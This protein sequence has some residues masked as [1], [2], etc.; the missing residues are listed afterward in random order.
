M[1]VTNTTRMGMLFCKNSLP[2]IF[3][4]HNEQT[5]F[6]ED[7]GHLCQVTYQDHKCNY[8]IQQTSI[9]EIQI[10]EYFSVEYFTQIICPFPSNIGRVWTSPQLYQRTKF[11]FSSACSNILQHIQVNLFYK[12]ILLVCSTWVRQETPSQ[13]LSGCD[14]IKLNVNYYI[15][16][17]NHNWS[18]SQ[19]S[20]P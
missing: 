17:S 6:I 15:T 9:Y 20:F 13:K 18:N 7:N 12:N 1:T 11:Y 4:L 19:K 3:L 2:L 14:E 10:L 5:L 8:A 16:T